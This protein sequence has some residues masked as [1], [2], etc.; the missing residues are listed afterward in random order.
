MASH[1]FGSFRQQVSKNIELALPEENQ[2][3]IHHG[4][5]PNVH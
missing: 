4:G 5:E 1:L 3:T 2:S